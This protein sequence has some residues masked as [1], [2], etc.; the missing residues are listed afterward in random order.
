MKLIVARD[1]E[2][3]SIRA[4]QEIA[5]VINSK[6]DAILGLATGGTPAGMY[7]KL[8][9]MNKEENLDFS[10]VTTVNLDEYIGLSSQHPKS[11]RFFM[12]ENL[13]DHVN[14]EKKNTF[15]PNGLAANIEEECKNYD[16]MID[17][18][19]GTDMQLL[20]V[21]S[22]GHI[23]FNEPDE[24]LVAGTHSTKLRESTINSNARF[25]NSIDEVPKTAITMGLGQ[26]MKAKKI[27]VLA[28]GKDKAEAIKGLMSGKITTSNPSTM[29]Q[30]HK[31]V[32]V[33]V[34]EDAASL[35]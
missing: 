3:M 14:I 28:S 11:Y 16:S 17:S 6:P 31:N 19:G 22:N 34:D 30:M 25:F 32:I 1:Y 24:D 9:E 20:G 23:A 2:D 15:L 29:L 27:L 7:K 33:I 4:A 10:K 35:L 8:I 18:L 5:K 12:D 21:G 13:F 26:I